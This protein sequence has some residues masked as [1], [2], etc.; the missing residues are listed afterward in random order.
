MGD[1]WRNMQEFNRPDLNKIINE[2]KKPI[3]NN[4]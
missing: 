4:K 1:F 3:E 2:E